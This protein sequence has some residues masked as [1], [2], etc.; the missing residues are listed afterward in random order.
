MK[1]SSFT[2]LLTIILLLAHQPLS[3]A[4]PKKQSY[5][6]SNV[7]DIL[8][9]MAGLKPDLVLVPYGWA[10]EEED[11][12]Q[13]GQELRK[14]VAKA[15]RIIRAPVVGVDLVGEIT[16]GPWTG[17]T[18]GGQSVAADAEGRI[19]AVAKDRDREVLVVQIT[20]EIDED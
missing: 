18:Y 1:P 13:H 19:I 6:C 15:A 10:A 12:P 4:K 9:R 16:H 5:P 8:T 17:K 2:K 20:I 14:T 11:W 7:S 3:Q